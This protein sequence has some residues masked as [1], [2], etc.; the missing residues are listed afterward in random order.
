MNATLDES[1]LP[2]RVARELRLDFGLERSFK[3][4][5]GALL[6]QRYLLGIDR[7]SLPPDTLASLL[8]MVGFPLQHRSR[9]EAAWPDAN[10]LL[11]GYERSERRTVIKVYLEF[12]ERIIAEVRARPGDLHP[13]PMFL[14]FKWDQADPGASR[15]TRYDCHPLLPLDRMI[16]RIQGLIS[17]ETP[18]RITEHCIGLAARRGASAAFKYLEVF[19]D[20]GTRRS[21]DLNL[22][23]GGLGL[24][25]IRPQLHELAQHY[26]IDPAVLDRQLDQVDGAAL[27][28]ISAGVSGDAGEFFSVYYEA[29]AP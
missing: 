23:S 8:R 26:Q 11:L 18:R 14:G 7:S 4:R 5:H 13:R 12:W 22:Y 15:V 20:D 2:L 27:G 1:S 10:L 17:A 28:H 6:W 9:F 21:F 25:D 16:G 3:M 29:P 19:D 24:R